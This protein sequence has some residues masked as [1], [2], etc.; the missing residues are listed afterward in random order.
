MSTLASDAGRRDGRL[1]GPLALVRAGARG[2]LVVSA[3][4][5]RD[6]GAGQPESRALEPT[7]LTGKKLEI[8]VKRLL[9]G[10]AP[11]RVVSRSAVANP[12][13]LDEIVEIARSG[14]GK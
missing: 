3:R 11:E 10:V 7:T 14:F 1:C 8:P 4:S 5:L 13:A 12:E 6:R 9:S 2:V